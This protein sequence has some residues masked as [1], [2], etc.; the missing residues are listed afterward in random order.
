MIVSFK[1]RGTEDIFDGNDSKAA[2]KTCPINLW[3]VAR[4]KLDQLNAAVSLNDLRV[5][6]GNKL[7]ALQGERAGQHSI[8]I[9][10]RYRICFVW[11]EQGADSVEIVDYHY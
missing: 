5:P 10:D 1:D 11:L 6:P 2:R 9:N 7:E 4:R 8:R 3:A